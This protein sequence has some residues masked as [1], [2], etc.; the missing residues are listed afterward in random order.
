M[1]ACDDSGHGIVWHTD[2]TL[3]LNGMLPSRCQLLFSQSCSV[4]SYVMQ[5]ALASRIV[6]TSNEFGVTSAMLPKAILSHC[7]CPGSGNVLGLPEHIRMT[8][9]CRV[10]PSNQQS[11]HVHS[12]KGHCFDVLGSFIQVYTYPGSDATGHENG[13]AHGGSIQQ[14][15]QPSKA[16]ML[17]RSNSVVCCHQVS[18]AIMKST[19][20]PFFVLQGSPRGPHSGWLL[21]RRLYSTSGQVSLHSCH[22]VHNQLS[23]ICWRTCAMLTNFAHHCSTASAGHVAGVCVYCLGTVWY[24]NSPG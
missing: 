3:Q 2:A 4:L 9:Y 1:T 13:S 17:M 8:A 19:K 5:Y 24:P 20:H 14:M 23:Y 16:C 10:I 6:S 22:L 18:S 11:K 21:I 7:V 12:F 15:S